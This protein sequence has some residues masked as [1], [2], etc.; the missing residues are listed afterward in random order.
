M[1][2]LCCVIAPSSPL[3]W[4]EWLHAR[5]ATVDS[6]ALQ[7]HSKI[8]SYYEDISTSEPNEA[9][10]LLDVCIMNYWDLVQSDNR[11]LERKPGP[12]PRT[13]IATVPSPD[14]AHRQ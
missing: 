8:K 13:T 7:V 3:S 9:R 14:P 11:S 5:V 12:S 6:S 1:F 4:D 2:V 10:N